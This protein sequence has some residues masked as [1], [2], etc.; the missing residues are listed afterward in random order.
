MIGG[1]YVTAVQ[2]STAKPPREYASLVVGPFAT[3]AEA[4]KA[5]PA[6]IK[7]VNEQ[8]GQGGNYDASLL[9]WGIAEFWFHRLVLGARNAELWAKATPVTR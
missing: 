2:R 5:G 3:W 4:D 9:E 1:Y 8:D 6:A 7:L